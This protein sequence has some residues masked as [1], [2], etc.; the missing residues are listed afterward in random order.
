MKRRARIKV[1]VNAIPVANVNTG[2]SRYLRCLYAQMERSYGDRLDIRYFDGIRVSKKMPGGPTNLNQ[3][4]RGVD[5]FWKLPTYP[6]LMARIGF[7]MLRE[8]AFR[9]LSRNFDI[10]HEAGFF[11][12]A[13]SSR[14]KTVFTIHDLSLVRFPNHHPRE[15]VLYSRLFLK[16]R[17]RRVDRFIAVSQFTSK[18]M[19]IYLRIDRES[20][21][22][23]PEAHE[24]EAFYSRSFDE[25]QEFRSRYSLPETFFLFVGGGDPRKNMD[26]IPEAL[27]KGGLDIPLVAIGWSGWGKH[28]PGSRIIPVGYVPDEEL[29]VAYSG[30][31]ALIFP[32]SYEGFGLP[33]LEA[34][35]CGCPVITTR[36][37]SLPEVAGEAALY[38][39]DPRNADE[40]AGFLK[41]L[42][43]NQA[44]AAD[45]R[46][47]GSM[48]AKTF[49]WE[50][51]AAATFEAF[52]KAL[53]Q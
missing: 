31:L 51:T 3:W 22:V 30:A 36:R 21:S 16:G 15:R 42:C 13:V 32:S 38:M 10:Y 20:I 50:K 6:A 1:I 39:E 35:A 12:F 40:L 48:Q 34:M 2:I 43:E 52:E 29:A 17:C 9:R 18:E 24:R 27:K 49:S 19:R 7:H 46:Q 33:I 4:T 11:P 45:L 41:R 53:D 25:I 14:I 28:K 37:A 8:A 44:L 5:L 26:I 23:T 47:K